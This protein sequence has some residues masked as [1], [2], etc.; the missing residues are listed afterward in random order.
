MEMLRRKEL[1]R[2]APTIQAA[3]ALSSSG[4]PSRFSGRLMLEGLGMEGLCASVRMFQKLRDSALTSLLLEVE[5][6]AL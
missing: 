3:P 2:G 1:L 6:G 4:E 5:W